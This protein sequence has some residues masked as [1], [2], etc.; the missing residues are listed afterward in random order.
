[1]NFKETL[2]K[3]EASESYQTFKQEHPD[4]QLC[5][6]F[7]IQDFL[8]NDSKDSIDYQD[9]DK[10]FTFN[11]IDNQIKMYEDKL[12]DLPNTPKLQPLLNPTTNIEVD[13]LKSI[14]QDKAH[15]EGIGAK[16]NKIIAVLQTHEENEQK[17]QIWNLTCMLDQL[18]ILHILIECYSGE[19]LK[20]QRKS[21][22]D[23]VKTK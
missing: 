18:I 22:M 13:E 5:A 14:A 9:Q 15:E 4:A 6:G 20:F 2:E 21:F 19:I 23:M 8:S 1:M 16:F 10:I 17:K 12:M 3:V 11:I 7:F